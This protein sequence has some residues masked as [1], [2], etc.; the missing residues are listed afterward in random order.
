MI[1]NW[2]DHERKKIHRQSI[3]KI[4][5]SL[6]HKLIELWPVYSGGNGNR[7]I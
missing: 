7:Q 1:T 4:E 3:L 2:I 6:P 5:K